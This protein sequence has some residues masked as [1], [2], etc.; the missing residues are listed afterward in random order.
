MYGFTEKYPENIF[1]N[2][3]IPSKFFLQAIKNL[4]LNNEEVLDKKY[5]IFI[6]L[7]LIDESAS[8]I[9]GNDGILNEEEILQVLQV[10]VNRL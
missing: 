2:V 10:C 5:D 1:D 3:E 6:E 8:L 9:I 7:N 4:K